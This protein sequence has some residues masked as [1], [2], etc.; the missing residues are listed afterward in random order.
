MHRY[1]L[2]GAL[3]MAWIS[4]S[5][6]GEIGFIEDFAL[7]RDR[8]AALKQLV[9][10]TEEYSYYHALHFLQTEQYEKID[11]LI[12][13][14]VQRHGETQRV[15]EIRTRYALAIYDKNPEKTL[16]FLK[17]RLGLYFPH[18]KEE[19]N[20][21]PNLPTTLDPRAISREAYI[22]R[23]NA[24]TTDNMDLFEDAALD[25]LVNYELNPNHR[26]SL[27]SRLSRPDHEKLVKHVVDDL[28]YQNSGGFGSLGIHRQ[29][30]ISQLEELAKAVPELLNQQQFVNAYLVKLQ[31]TADEDWQHDPKR[32]EAYLE[33]LQKFT[34]RL[35]P[36]HNS[37]KA[38]VLYHRLVLDR[39]RGEFNKERFIE[40]LKLPRRVG[41]LSKGMTESE[42]F[43]KTPSDLSANFADTT[44]LPTIND[45]ATVVRSFL[46]H[47][48]VDAANT[49]AFEPYINDIYLQHLFAEVK[50]LNGLGDVEQWA[51]LLP[52]AQF[53]ELKERVDLDF[54]FTN[55]TRFDADERVQLDL[56][57][58]NVGTLIV[59]VFEI[60][61]KAYYRDQL[62][63]VD[64]DISLDG[65]VANFEQTHALNDSPLRRT[66]KKFEFPQL[67][68][69]GIY[70]VDFIG[71]GRSS[72]AL[73]RKGGLRHLVHVAPVGQVF[74]I[75]NDKNEQIKD[76]T[77]W[78]SGHE[79]VA[80]EEGTILVPFTANAVRQPVVITHG[81]LSSL[82]FFQHE[83]E[84]PGLTVGFYVDREALL[85]QK[86]AQLI[87]RPGVT[88]NGI[89]VSVKLLDNV[90][91]TIVST[92]LDG[93]STTQETADFKLFEDREA[94]HEFQVPARLSS[95]TFTLSAQIK[96]HSEGGRQIDLSASDTITLNGLDRTDKIESLNLA[97]TNGTYVLELRGKTGEAKPSRPI[98]ISM[99]HR[100]FR[101]MHQVT[102][103]T[104]ATGRITLGP[105]TDIVAV[106][107]VNPENSPQTWN[108]R[109][110][111]HTWPLVVHGQVGT[112]ISVPFLNRGG[113]NLDVVPPKANE[114]KA[115]REELSLLEVRNGVF[116]AD[117]F[118]HLSLK[119]GFVVLS[120]LTPGDF[121]LFL[122]SSGTQIRVR[123]TEGP[124][125][126]DFILGN[127]RQ[128]ETPKLAPIQ[129]ESIHPA[130][131][132]VAIQLKNA[133]KF[134][135]VHVY[136]TRYLP[137]YDIFSKLSRVRGAEP[138]LFQQTA[139]NSVYLT[140]R[141][142]GDEYRYI[143]DRKYAAK[144]PGNTLDRPSLL[145][146]PWAVRTTETGEQHA[147][148]GD[149]F[150]AAGEKPQSVRMRTEAPPA[151]PQAPGGSFAN[152]DFLSAGSATLINL[153]PDKDGLIEIPSAA[154]G[155][156][157]HIHVVAVDPLNTTYRS[158]SLP[159]KKT[160][161]LDLRLE[162][163]L[164]P[165]SHFTQQKQ[166]SIVPV[167]QT[168]TLHDITTSKF[169]A[170]DSLSRVFRL[171]LT[172][173]PDPKLIEFS[174]LMNWPGLTA[175]QKRSLYSKHA[176]HELSFF[177]FKKDPEF[178]QTVIKP[179][180][181]N[182]K[183]PT[184]VDRFL[185]EEDLSEFLQPWK[186]G[187]LNIV[188]RILL[189]RIIKDERPALIRHIGDLYSLLPPKQD[190]FIRLFDTSVKRSS[191][192]VADT[193]GL[194][195]ATD[196]LIE[197]KVHEALVR[198]QAAGAP[199]SYE[200]PSSDSRGVHVPAKAGKSVTSDE[201]SKRKS[202]LGRSKEL[203]DK[204]QEAAKNLLQ[205]RA[206]ARFHESESQ[207]SSKDKN[208]DWSDSES[209]NLG[210]KPEVFFSK[211]GIA[212]GGDLRQLYR[213]LEKTME[214]AENNYHHLPID[215]QN[216]NLIT[217]NRFWK[218]FAQHDPAGPF[219][220]RSLAEASRNFPEMLLA[221]A[222]LDLP[223]EAP[224]HETKFAGTGMTL[225]PG[226]PLIVFHEE[227][228]PSAGPDG[229]TNVLV[230]QNFYRQGDRTQIVEGEQIDK[231]VKDEF[232]TQ[233]VYGCQIVVT[234]PTSTR[235]TLSVLL[236]IPRGSLPVLN[237]QATKTVQLTLEP[238]HTQTLDYHFYF[239][240]PGEF[241]HFPVH[242]AKN[243]TLIAATAPIRF[244][245]VDKPTKID[246]RSWDYVSQS[247]STEDLLTF[248]DKHN[249]H[250]LNLDRIAWRMHDLKSFQAIVARLSGQHVYHH[251]LWSYSLKHNI[252]ARIREFLLHADQIVND[253]GGRLRSPLVELDPVER[254]TFEHLEYKP[255]VNARAHALGKRRQ[256]VN[257]RFLEQYHRTLKQLA[258]ERHLGDDDLLTVTYYLLLQ[259]RIEEAIATFAQVNVDAVSTKMQFDYCAAYLDFF[260]DDHNR[261]RAIARKYV[262]HPVDRWRQTFAAITAQLDE[263]DGK[264]FG[265]VN[266]DDRDQQ[267]TRLAASEPA[268]DFT[269]EAKQ[270]K[271]DS[272]N[273]QS[274]RVNFYEMDVELLFSRNPFVQQFR[275][276][277]SSIQPNISLDVAIDP[278][279][280]QAAEKDPQNL[281]KTIPLPE[282]LQNKN[283]LVEIVASGITKT[284]AYYSHSLTVQVI[285]NYGQVKVTRQQGGEPVPKAYVKVYSQMA[286]GRVK[287]YKDGYTDLRGR[288]DFASLNTNDLDVATKFSI[289]I[290]SD[291]YGAVVR[292]A[293]PPK[294]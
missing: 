55:K 264:N 280:G 26:R 294:R 154:I 80:G 28:K 254:R 87:V 178:F 122:K 144:F 203:D 22:D 169:E 133:T 24:V 129:I 6:G 204:Q 91:L 232:L 191:L 37:L 33:R 32:L 267:Q 134:T 118:E 59:K 40:Y 67:D 82:D 266:G 53:R 108:L 215:Q 19:L 200:A 158:I 124:K 286:D 199:L 42:A 172:L 36:V 92:D 243:E 176:C 221:L 147:E 164:N 100:D 148:F 112:T 282:N 3:S 116:V 99:K 265:P 152:L 239:P 236:Q 74:T 233:V 165:E 85:K 272:Q 255:L 137:E 64:T 21:E 181:A 126:D 213:K 269:L 284:Q 270:I 229:S 17:G 51:A 1:I 209:S 246:M 155:T 151:A 8:S 222:V 202:S 7:A 170:Y 256:I 131:E 263:A 83:T 41:Y 115:T 146:N 10:G 130:G 107:A 139:A 12:A 249:V 231:F 46:A 201:L 177:L 73:I 167:G 288:F 15:W 25:W 268:F 72:R 173:N 111:Q 245:V 56:F 212:G 89:P 127:F 61:T 271:L 162:D 184:F 120:K 275:G 153:V 65:L 219:L 140:G 211:L 150:A 253:C 97:K 49:K 123:V 195:G 187:Q 292:E 90:K 251:T 106:T 190:N 262:D 224:K 194:K 103:K 20:A 285:E 109:A 279:A 179:Y 47:F 2:M 70:V 226:G 117:R 35:S 14:W 68:K 95:L 76:A 237:S 18:Q 287:F 102:L 216:A 166:I 58:K 261:A 75:L 240:A 244:N 248:F 208:G 220:S 84:N 168:F 193:F 11:N 218:D 5:L 132:G 119:N 157:Q 78:L 259:D 175:E 141:N 16:D 290:L 207:S 252:P 138:A 159:E 163:G 9:P 45:D 283:V 274:V 135:R 217:V 29:L 242:V 186:F 104:D 145:L 214:W 149:T 125:R 52:P 205:R 71:N 276:Q 206:S 79:Y 223:F 30:M 197:E 293:T 258:Y 281:T 57:V 69:P 60:N 77:L 39:Q 23:A 273:I 182:K 31:P 50:I 63:E 247:G 93:I 4:C 291:E 98:Q 225:T 278:N 136:A 277:F 180:L 43:K 94:S 38:H 54:A 238:Y 198:E 183:D 156:H 66:S 86:R 27:L 121:D 188:E 289:L 142:I 44:R 96:K 185:L 260:T 13:T 34:N 192:E 105:M 250:A 143:I 88:M 210:D 174:F 161:F 101:L 62:Q 114:S 128:L 227:I 257:D 81:P 160:D 230:S 110:D 48:L 234:N 196:R 241:T 235:Q 113:L 189:S 228:R 171:Y